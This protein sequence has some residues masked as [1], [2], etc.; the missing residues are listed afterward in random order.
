[1]RITQ[2]YEPCAQVYYQHTNFQYKTNISQE[3]KP[4]DN[5]TSSIHPLETQNMDKSPHNSLNI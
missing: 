4:F 3:L 5:D 1:M 2:Q